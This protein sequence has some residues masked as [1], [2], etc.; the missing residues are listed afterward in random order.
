M[1]LPAFLDFRSNSRRFIQ[2]LMS[3]L[4][5]LRW[6]S[7]AGA[8][9]REDKAKVYHCTS[10]RF[11]RHPKPAQLAKPK[12]HREKLGFFRSFDG[13]S[14]LFLQVRIEQELLAGPFL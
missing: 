13:A 8:W 14:V 10:P 6:H 5:R 3:T 7:H 12:T 4:E 1:V 9:D 11:I 2:T